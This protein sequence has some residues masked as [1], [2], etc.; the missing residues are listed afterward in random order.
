MNQVWGSKLSSILKQ[1]GL[2][3]LSDVIDVKKR[4]K[5]LEDVFKDDK[6][7]VYKSM[8]KAIEEIN[9]VAVDVEYSM[10][11]DEEKKRLSN[12]VLSTLDGI[13]IWKTQWI[14]ALRRVKGKATSEQHIEW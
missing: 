14:E 3:K 8:A 5:K 13:E 12:V 4:G 11:S 10:L 9:E 7:L 2:E 1:N 6:E